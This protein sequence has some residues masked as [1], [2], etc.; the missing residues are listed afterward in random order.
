LLAWPSGREPVTKAHQGFL[1]K[2]CLG[3]PS[4]TGSKLFCHGVEIIRRGFDAGIWVDQLEDVEEIG[5]DVVQLGLCPFA[6]PYV[7]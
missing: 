6:G 7:I 4:R 5:A 1:E 3:A 2:A